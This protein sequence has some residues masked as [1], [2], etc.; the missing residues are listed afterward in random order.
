MSNTEPVEKYLVY[1]LARLSK[2]FTKLGLGSTLQTSGR[3]EEESGLYRTDQLP[4]QADD[5]TTQVLWSP[6][7][8]KN[9]EDRY[10]S[11]FKAVITIVSSRVK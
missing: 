1:P 5:V 11:Q 8:E 9:E 2:L 10:Y 3:T 4:F 6:L 7:W